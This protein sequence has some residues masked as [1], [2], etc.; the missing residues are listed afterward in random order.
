MITGVEQSPEQMEMSAMQ[1]QLAMQELQLGIE[2]IG[3]EIQKLQ[4]E[5]AVNMAEVQDTAEIAPQLKM[6]ELQSEMRQKEMELQLRRELADLT[7][8]TRVSN[9]ET[10]AATRIATTA[11]QQTNKTNQG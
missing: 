6:M 9:Q 10:S 11:M 1:Q 4:S 8:Q 5:A 3:A 2:K 7:N